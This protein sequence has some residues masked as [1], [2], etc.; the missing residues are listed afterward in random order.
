M[1]IKKMSFLVLICTFFCL[2]AFSQTPH[3]TGEITVSVEKGIINCDFTLSQI[4][5]IEQYTIWLHAGFNMARITDETQK[6]KYK[7]EKTY[8][9]KS[10]EAF[11]YTL[12]EQGKPKALPGLLRFAYTGAFPVISDTS[13]MYDRAD[14]KGN[15]A[16]NGTSVRMS[17][18][19]AWYPILYNVQQD[20][21]INNYTY[22]IKVISDGG[23][24]VYVNGDVP[25]AGSSNTF[26]ST[27]PV[28]MLLFAGAFTFEKQQGV[29]FVNT[30][31]STR[32]QT[33][34]CNWTNTMKDFYSAKLKI[35][36][37]GDITYIQATPVSKE[38]NWAFV[39][40]PTIAVIG[41]LFTL[42]SF[43]NKTTELK[44]EPG[45]L[46][47]LSHEAGH[48]YFGN[49][50]HS[51][52]DLQ[53]VFLEGFTEYMSL[54]FT[55]EKLGKEAYQK[56]LLQ[57]IKNINAAGEVLALN[58]VSSLETNEMYR[59]SYSPL[60]LTALEKQ[61]G[62]KQMWKWLALVANSK[63]ATTNY[64]FFKS[65]L[66]NSGVSEKKYRAFEDTFINHPNRKENLL[67]AVQDLLPPA[68]PETGK[69]AL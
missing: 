12:V 51:N 38:N 49:L 37:K 62:T 5:A 9:Q 15:I 34:L 22:S 3:L 40:Y 45:N 65:S 20:K 30:G 2:P 10:D 16:F 33:L 53:W 50:F 6:I 69:S 26:S 24:T 19:S 64:A 43:F 59:Y 4:P 14:W 48:Y 13:L 54:Q 23:S 57:Y 68:S 39:S 41:R 47:Y 36:Y 17:E 58:K 18:Q 1:R 56:G 27:N 8:N 7:Y 35:P 46:R 32:E 66:L 60:L 67:T 52:S 55:K 31:L 25:K 11:Q 21:I 61:I 29:Y 42:N 28:P 63:N 44:I